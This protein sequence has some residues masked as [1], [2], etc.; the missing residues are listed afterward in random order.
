LVDTA[1]CGDE[2]DIWGSRLK[3]CN[4]LFAVREIYSEA[5]NYMLISGEERKERK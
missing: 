4:S 5:G 3:T 2:K 1:H